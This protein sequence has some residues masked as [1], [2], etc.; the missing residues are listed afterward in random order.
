MGI[1]LA[2]V[3]S[4]QGRDKDALVLLTTRTHY[5]PEEGEFLDDPHRVN[6]AFARCRHGQFILCQQVSL[7]AVLI[8]DQNA[9]GVLSAIEEMEEKPQDD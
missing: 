1:V 9:G 6:V 2:T 7:V 8:W 3:D 5:D 4:I